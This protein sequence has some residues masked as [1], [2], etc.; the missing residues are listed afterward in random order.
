MLCC[1]HKEGRSDVW[2]VYL[3]DSVHE[4][5]DVVRLIE[6]H[7]G[8]RSD[9]IHIIH[10]YHPTATTIPADLLFDAP[11]VAPPKTR[12]RRNWAVL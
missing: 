3:T 10:S 1:E 6:A 7:S 4:R 2:A 8:G 5:N 9:R 12:R 11:Q